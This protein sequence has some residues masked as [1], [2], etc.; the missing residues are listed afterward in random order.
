MVDVCGC[1]VAVRCPDEVFGRKADPL[2]Q[3]STRAALGDLVSNLA[4]ELGQEP[5][6]PLEQLGA[7]AEKG[8]RVPL[9]DADLLAPV[10]QPSKII[11]IGLNYADHIAETAMDTPEVPTLP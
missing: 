8:R 1:R 4:T 11:A 10:N 6:L 9:D 5:P 3:T 7:A 2:G